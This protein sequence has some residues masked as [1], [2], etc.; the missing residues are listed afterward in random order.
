MDKETHNKSSFAS[1]YSEKTTID[2]G[3]LAADAKYNNKD[4]ELDFGFS[5]VSLTNNNDGLDC[6]EVFYIN[7]QDEKKLVRRLDLHIMPLFCLFYFADFL[8]RAN[9]GNAT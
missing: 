9:I 5:C 8:D 2:E 1:M 3:F 6:K 7:D 4:G